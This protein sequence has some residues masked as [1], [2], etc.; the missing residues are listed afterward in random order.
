MVKV[1]LSLFLSSEVSLLVSL[2]LLS[3]ENYTLIIADLSGM[4]RYWSQV[5]CWVLGERWLA[6]CLVSLFGVSKD[7]VGGICAGGCF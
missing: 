2:L 4:E 6:R 7:V 3:W 1:V 5:E